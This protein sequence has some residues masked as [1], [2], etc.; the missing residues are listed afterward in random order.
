MTAFRSDV[1]LGATNS[2][3]RPIICPQDFFKTPPRRRG[4]NTAQWQ[5]QWQ[6]HSQWFVHTASSKNPP[7]L[8][9]E[10]QGQCSL[11][12]NAAR[13]PKAGMEVEG[14]QHCHAIQAVEHANSATRLTPHASG[15]TPRT[16]CCSAR[17]SGSAMYSVKR[18]RAGTFLRSHRRMRPSRPLGICPQPQACHSSA[19]SV[20]T[21]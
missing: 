12:P 9:R 1:S 15:H 19:L 16:F 11:I 6:W 3:N 5:W 4:P 7:M 2:L 14:V 18:A 20:H 10:T 13:E 8:A 17:L 21:T